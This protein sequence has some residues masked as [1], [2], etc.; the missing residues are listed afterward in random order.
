LLR[1]PWPAKR[2]ETINDINAWLCNFW[3]AVKADPD[4]VAFYAADPV[5]ELDLQ[6]RGDWLFYRPNVDVEFVERL[7][8]DPDYYDAKSAGWWVWGQSSWIGDDWGRKKC[9]SLPHLGAG[10]GVNRQRPHLSDAGTG[11]ETTRLVSIREYMR[12]LC[13][14]MAGVRVCCGD[15]SRVLGPA[16]TIAHG[17]CGVFLDPPY[18]VAD[19][20]SV[21]GEH[22]DRNIAND[23]R[24]WC[25]EWGA[26]PPMRIVL[27]GYDGEHNDLVSNGWTVQAWKASGGYG[28]QSDG[29]ENRHRERL[30]LSPHCLRQAALRL[31]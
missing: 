3:R 15:W 25:R 29:N 21:Y 9:R 11:D 24:D 6:A 10:K 18:A 13:E 22:E 2:T 8:S 17:T 31:E 20:D 27:C 4:K 19:R 28:N 12:Q 1:A 30:W 14:R 5:S 16:I 26:H 23:V 7:R